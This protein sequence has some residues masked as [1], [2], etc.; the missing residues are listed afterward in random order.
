ML[1]LLT[2]SVYCTKKISGSLIKQARQLQF[3][4]LYTAILGNRFQS[5]GRH[6]VV[7]F[8]N[9][10][11]QKTTKFYGTEIVHYTFDMY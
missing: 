4:K 6:Q 11:V 8:L 1:L 9:I 7:D 10:I 2:R 3:Q 5:P